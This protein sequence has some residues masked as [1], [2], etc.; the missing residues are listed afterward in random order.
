MKRVVKLVFK[1]LL[2]VFFILGGINHFVRPDF[3][4]NLMPD[5]IPS[6]EIM[7]Q[8][9]G[10]TEIIAGVMLLIPPISRWGAWFIIAHLVVFFTVHFWMIQHAADRYSD[11]PLVALWFRIVLQ[12]IFIAWAMWF[13]NDGKPALTKPVRAEA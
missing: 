9:S 10:V 2:G 12:V 4:L 11:I 5:Y 3:Y 6:H 7:V 13:I 1:V 8:L